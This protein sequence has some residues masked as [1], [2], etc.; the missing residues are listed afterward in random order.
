MAEMAVRAGLL[1]D[2]VSDRAVN[3]NGPGRGIGD[4]C[5]SRFFKAV[6]RGFWYL[7]AR[8]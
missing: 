7:P 3:G 1:S 4:P 8:M 2:A 6:R 5:P